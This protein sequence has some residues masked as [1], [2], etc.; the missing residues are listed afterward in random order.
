ML[1]SPS[2]AR[3]HVVLAESLILPPAAVQPSERRAI[4]D[5]ARAI[6]DQLVQDAIWYEERCTWLGPAR[7]HRQTPP[8]DRPATYGVVGPDLYCGTAGIALFLAQLFAETGD[9]TYRTAARGA[10]R[11]LQLARNNS[12]SRTAPGSTPDGQAWP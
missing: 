10:V 12:R 8:S 1:E 9:R 7:Q 11:Q 5:V 2:S 3:R 6:G 4:V